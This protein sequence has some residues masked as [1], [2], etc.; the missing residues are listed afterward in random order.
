M[1]EQ[2]Y[3]IDNLYQA[4]MK[5]KSTSG[6]KERT[7][8]YDED[9]LFNLFELRKKLVN[10][11]YRPSQPLTFELVERGKRR[12]IESYNIE[13]RI[14]QRCLV[15]DVLLPVIRPKLI[16]DNDAS[17]KGRGTSHFRNRLSYKLGRYARKHGEDGYILI[18]DFSKFFDNIKHDVFIN[19]LSELGVDGEVISFVKMILDAHKTDVS[20]LDEES[21]EGCMESVFDALE[22][23][24]VDRHKLNGTKMMEKSVGIGSPLAQLAGIVVPYR[25]DNYVKIVIGCKD[26]A[27]YNDDF[28]II[29]HDKD[30][31]MKVLDGISKICG[32]L[33]LHL[34]KKK[35]HIIPLHHRFT[36]LK[37]QYHIQ[38]NKVIE[39]PAKR[40]YK[41][42]RDKLRGLH[43][44]YE[45]GEITLT[46]TQNMYKSWRNTMTSRK[47]SYHSM[48]NMD[49]YFANLFNKEYNDMPE[50]KK[51]DKNKVFD[52]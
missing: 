34:N 33:G 4:W 30:F 12:L 5:V 37:T 31:L 9:I 52:W 36:L 32:D 41:R 23:N 11:T 40:S 18:A 39:I 22:H 1:I 48:E 8:R 6:W 50:K 27:R 14:V 24:K 26:Y 19:A 15:Q 38:D 7:Q 43:R 28:Y 49:R 35:T 46:K 47:G 13:D 51:P 44:K 16:Y 29:H 17:V 45:K 25:I 42:E 20:Y 2:L 10:G 21:Y 3:D